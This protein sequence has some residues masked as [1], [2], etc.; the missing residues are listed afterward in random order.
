ML[1]VTQL[2]NLAL[3]IRRKLEAFSG[4]FKKSF[5]IVLL[6]NGNTYALFPVLHLVYMKKTNEN[7]SCMH[8]PWSN[9]TFP[10][11]ICE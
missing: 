3:S 5:K 9:R 7:M 8:D 2:T 10:Y 4:L 11:H 6:H 1:L